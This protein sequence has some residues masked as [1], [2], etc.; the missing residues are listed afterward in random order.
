MS[1]NQMKKYE[2]GEKRR[3]IH[4]S[5]YIAYCRNGSSAAVYII[6]DI[7]D[8]IDTDDKWI[9]ITY[10]QTRNNKEGLN[11]FEYFIAELFPRITKPDYSYAK[12]IDEM[13]YITWST[14]RKDIEEHRKKGYNGPIYIVY[15][16]IE[17]IVYEEI[18][19]KVYELY[20]P[21]WNKW[22]ECDEGAIPQNA[23]YRLKAENVSRKVK[24]YSYCID[25][26]KKLR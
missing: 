9:D 20:Y 15:P 18:V 14:A 25:S 13:K 24:S 3:K 11:D 22:F 6:R 12:S 23:V 8:K 26:L 10:I 17:N 21:K 4:D 19:E 16:R 5:E 1:R 2:K 7:A